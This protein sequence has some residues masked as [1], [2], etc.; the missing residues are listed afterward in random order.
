MRIPLKY[1]IRA[2]R[3][4]VFTRPRPEADFAALQQAKPRCQSI[5][6]PAMT[7]TLGGNSL[8]PLSV[9]AR[10]RTLRA[11]RPALMRRF[12][13]R[14]FTHCVL[15]SDSFTEAMM[16]VWPGPFFASRH[17]FVAGRQ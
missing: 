17:S 16:I 5:A 15:G 4:L 1:S 11:H 9:S 6:S 3:V 7:S 12:V 8:T 2:V 10:R 13:L 14:L